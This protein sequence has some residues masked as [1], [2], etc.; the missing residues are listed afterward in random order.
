MLRRTPCITLTPR[1]HRE[2]RRDAMGP[3][4]GIYRILYLAALDGRAERKPR[5]C[6]GI[7]LEL[8]GS[9]VAE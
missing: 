7:P 4:D 8:S 6:V 2:L 9:C 5:M 1:R 3:R